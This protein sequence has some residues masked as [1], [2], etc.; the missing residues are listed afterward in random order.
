MLQE[1]C[2]LTVSPPADAFHLDSPAA[3]PITTFIALCEPR[4]QPLLAAESKG[5]GM[6]VCDSCL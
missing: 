3:Q 6:N 5:C 1:Q 4:V 2:Y